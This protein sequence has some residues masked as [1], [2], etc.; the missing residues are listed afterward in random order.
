MAE[1]AFDLKE[2]I[3][4]QLGLQELPEDKRAELLDQMAQLVERRV[5]LRLIDQLSEDDVAAIAELE[6]R[7]EELLAFM[8]K[9]VPDISVLISEEAEKV[10]AEA[11]DVAAEEPEP[12]SAETMSGDDE[13][14]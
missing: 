2:N 6:E 11:R 14:I 3:I 7:P 5:M 1:E 8:A 12:A 10:K 13:M 9:K 4:A